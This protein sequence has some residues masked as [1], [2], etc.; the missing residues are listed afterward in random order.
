MITPLQELKNDATKSDIK[1]SELLRRAKI[2][3]KEIGDQNFLDWIEKEADG[4][5]NGEGVPEYRIVHGE[6]RGWNP[7]HGWVPWII[8]D[9]EKQRKISQRGVSQAIGELEQLISERSENSSL[10]MS[11][12]EELQRQAS[13]SIGLST[14]FTLMVPQNAIVGI[15]EAVRNKLLD[16]LILIDGSDTKIK[17]AQTI[18]K[19]IFPDELIRKLDK[20]IKILADDF[21][22]NFEN[23]RPVTGM[24]ILRR[25]LPL[26]IVRKFQKLKREDEIKNSNRDYFNTKAL[27][28]KVKSLLSNK[29]I[30]SELMNYKFLIDSSQHSY[31]LNVQMPDT[32]GAAIKLRVFLDDIF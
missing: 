25:I 28:E 23:G 5:G 15:L 21:N 30:Y 4:Y 22:F 26:A 7:Y 31:T 27:L 1:V 24:L 18:R 11:Y 13:R 9:P 12:P 10:Q 32:E 29:R 17:N 19:I 14:K 2:I 16:W 20:D 3:A 8:D 6:P